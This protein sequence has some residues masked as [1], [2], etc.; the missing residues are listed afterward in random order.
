[1]SKYEERKNQVLAQVDSGLTPASLYVMGMLSDAQEAMR[2][3]Q[4]Q[5][6]NEIMNDAKI[7]IDERLSNKD[8]HGRHI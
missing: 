3:G 1:M 7:I 4:I 5:L 8:E 6:A 2:R